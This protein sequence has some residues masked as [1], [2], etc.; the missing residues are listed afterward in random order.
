MKNDRILCSLDDKSRGMLETIRKR[1][2]LGFLNYYH[3]QSKL[4]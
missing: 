4:G 2:P 3:M 1:K